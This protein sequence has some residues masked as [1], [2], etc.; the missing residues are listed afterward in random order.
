LL[1]QNHT[2]NNYPFLYGHSKVIYEQTEQVDWVKDQL[3]AISSNNNK[4]MNGQTP[5]EKAEGEIANRFD[6]YDFVRFLIFLKNPLFKAEEEFRCYFLL[7]KVDK[8]L[9]EF[10]R[11]KDSILVPFIKLKVKKDSPKLLPIVNVCVGPTNKID[12]A[13]KGME[14]FLSNA[15]YPKVKVIKSEIP[16]RY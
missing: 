12:L 10:T 1:I 13:K 16:L 7:H 3:N 9:V 11:T 4:A 15:G 5:R 14:I 8:R 6:E 2:T